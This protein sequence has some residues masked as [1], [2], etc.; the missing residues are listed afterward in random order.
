MSAAKT[1]FVPVRPVGNR[2][3]I[4]RVAVEEKTPSG[5]YIPAMAQEKPSEATVVAVGPGKWLDNGTRAAP[6]VQLGDVVVISKWGGT[7][8]KVDGR[9]YSVVTEDD[10]LCIKD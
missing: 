6:Q 5:L 9:D 7:E 4:S 1:P 2:I 8:I 3:V 10:V